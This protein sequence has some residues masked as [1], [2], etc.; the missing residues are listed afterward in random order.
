M[1]RTYH[2]VPGALYWN[3]HQPC[4]WDYDLERVPIVRTVSGN[5]GLWVGVPSRFTCVEAGAVTR[6]PG[7]LDGLYVRGL[8]QPRLGRGSSTCRFGGNCFG[9]GPAIAATPDRIFAAGF[10][11]LDCRR[12]CRGPS[13]AYLSRSNRH[14]P[15]PPNWRCHAWRQWNLHEPKYP[16]VSKRFATRGGVRRTKSPKIRDHPGC[17]RLLGAIIAGK[18]LSRRLAAWRGTKDPSA[19]ESLSQGHRRRE[20]RY[21]RNCA[22]GCGR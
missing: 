18:S 5:R 2:P 14:S 21:D 19:P 9:P 22:E 6:A 13:T 20:N 3:N 10:L 7:C 15:R 11:R 12:F 4:P 17:G 1:E 8:Q 16:R